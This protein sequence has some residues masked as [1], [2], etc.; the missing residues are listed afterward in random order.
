MTDSFL[1]TLATDL[2]ARF[3]EKISEVCIIFPT[4]RAKL[5]FRQCLFQVYQKSLWLPE[6]YSIEDWVCEMNGGVFP[7]ALELIVLLHGVYLQEMRKINPHFHEKLEDFY[8]WGEILL[9]DFEEVDKYL[10]DAKQLYS[11]L[12]DLKDIEAAI[13]LP[14]EIQLSVQKFLR[15]INRE[16]YTRIQKSFLDLWEVLYPV[17][18]SFREKLFRI[19]RFYPGMAYRNVAEKIKLGVL[20]LK[21]EHI[22]FA[23]LNLLSRSEEVILDTLLKSGKASVYW[24]ILVMGNKTPRPSLLK[25]PYSFIRTYHRKWRDNHSFLIKTELAS[26]EKKINIIGVPQ[27]VGQARFTGENLLPHLKNSQTEPY[28]IGVILPDEQLLFPILYALPKETRALNITMGFPLKNTHI[29]QLLIAILSLLRS[30]KKQANGAVIFYYRPLLS[31]FQNPFIKS[32]IPSLSSEICLRLGKE[33]LVWATE[34][35]LKK[36]PLPLVLQQI[37][38]LPNDAK[39]G[40]EYMENTLSLLLQEAEKDNRK[41][42]AE[43]LFFCF[44]QFHR[45]R[46]I[47]QG[48]NLSLKGLLSLLKEGFKSIKVPF[49]GEPLEGIQI[50]GLLETRALDFD[51]LFIMNANEGSL[52]SERAQN[53]FIPNELRKGFQLPREQQRTQIISY[54]FYRLIQRAKQVYIVY[55]TEVKSNGN[56]GEASR[57]VLQLR[58]LFGSGQFSGIQLSQDKITLPAISYARRAIV[59]PNTAEIRKLITDKYG[60]TGEGFHTLSA[61]SLGTYLSCSLK[62]YFKYIA[63]LKEPKIVEASIDEIKL[64]EMIHKVMEILYHPYVKAVTVPEDFEKL[65]RKVHQVVKEVFIEFGYDPENG[66]EGKNYLSMQLIERACKWFITH[67]LEEAK[68]NPFVIEMLERKNL[69]QYLLNVP[70]GEGI[71]PIR[72]DGNFDR[73]DRFKNQLRIVD[74][75]TGTVA[76]QSKVEI[77]KIFERSKSTPPKE[78]QGMMYAFLLSE[79]EPYGNHSSTV[80]FYSLKKSGK[81]MQYMNKGEAIPA[82]L[83]QDFKEKLTTVIQEILVND[84]EQTDKI[85]VCKYCEFNGICNLQQ[86]EEAET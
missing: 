24:D 69:F 9:R 12:K 8:T 61:T 71:V 37:L 78:L 86:D 64:G 5:F 70:L 41:L 59:I 43:Y 33:N 79:K 51:V 48:E 26:M 31:I 32:L 60:T 40:F 27:Q 84:F 75:K 47:L 57:F 50:M 10:V 28:R 2:K 3:G 7:E 62:F 39:E 1:Y 58:H 21:H 85:V 73:L 23:G 63:E 66:L 45:L 34:N 19:E 11:N 29:Y 4:R 18:L 74:Y 67:D 54:H 68:R 52:P 13:G 72:L 20:E 65:L 42:E 80:G 25:L 22:V 77:T 44:R 35:Y 53:S 14:E 49:E 56:S 17:Y 81:A 36:N 46:D 38:T 76:L 30:G 6:I 83:I 82:S 55:N 15:S 16:N